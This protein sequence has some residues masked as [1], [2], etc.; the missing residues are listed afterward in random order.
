M[1]EIKF[2]GKVA[3]DGKW[4]YGDLAHIWDEENGNFIPAISQLGDYTSSVEPETIGQFTG[5]K[6]KNGKEIYEGDIVKGKFIRYLP[7]KK[8]FK[9]ISA[10]IFE[11]GMFRIKCRYSKW[12]KKFYYDSFPYS[13]GKGEY[14]K[15]IGNIFENPKQEG[16]K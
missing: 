3:R 2:R 13:H 16:G 15:I 4:I 14:F 12:S 10:V 11:H 5:L 7:E 9:I 6:D 8:I 1:R